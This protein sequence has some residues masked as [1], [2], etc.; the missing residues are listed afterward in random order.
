MEEPDLSY[1]C[2]L[3]HICWRVDCESRMEPPIQT[4]YLSSGGAML[5]IFIVL[6]ARAVIFFC[7]LSGMPRYMVVTPDSTVLA[8]RSLQMSTSHFMIQLKVVS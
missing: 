6:C 8:Y 1:S 5:L 7:I 4:E 3:I 2:L